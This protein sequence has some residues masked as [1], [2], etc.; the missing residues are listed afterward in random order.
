M[1][2]ELEPIQP[3]SQALH[4]LSRSLNHTARSPGG[5]SMNR[6]ANVQIPILQLIIN[7]TLQGGKR[8]LRPSLDGKSNQQPADAALRP[9]NRV[10]ALTSAA[11]PADQMGQHVAASQARQRGC[12]AGALSFK[13]WPRTA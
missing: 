4:A 9:E 13:K 1:F 6:A 2:M 10:G 7:D 8:T 5:S 3:Q 12:W 11:A